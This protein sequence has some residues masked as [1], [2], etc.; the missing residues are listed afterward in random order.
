[1]EAP[2]DKTDE[3]SGYQGYFHTKEEVKYFIEELSKLET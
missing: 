3:A 2:A 1:V